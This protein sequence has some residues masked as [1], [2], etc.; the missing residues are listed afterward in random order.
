MSKG[1]KNK[2]ERRAIFPG[3][4]ID[5]ISTLKVRQQII[6]NPSRLKRQSVRHLLVSAII[7][8]M[9]M[10]ISCSSGGSSSSDMTM[11]E[12]LQASLDRAI[13]TYGGKGVSVAVIL[14]DGS[15]WIGTSGTS[16]GSVPVS[17]NMLFSIGSATKTFTAVVILQL[18]EDGVLTLEDQLSEWLP[19][20]DNIDS[21]I[22]I[23]QLLNHTSGI[24]NCTEHPEIWD[25]I[26]ADLYA[27]WTMEEIIEGYI[28]PPDF[29][30]GTDWHYSNTGYLLLRMIIK[31]ATGQSISSQYRERLFKPT[32]MTGM[33]TAI[34]E[35]P[36]GQVA[37]GW[38]DTDN[39]GDYDDFSSV[40]QTAFY[41]AIGGGVFASAKE[42][43]L[44]V[45]AVWH[46][47]ILLSSDYYDHMM[48]FHSPTPG[49]PLAAGYGLGVVLFNPDLFNGLTI[50]GHAGNP[51]GYAAGG[52]YLA[53]YGVSI[54]IL[55]NTE[56]G[57]TMPVINEILRIITKHVS[58]NSSN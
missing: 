49:E 53:D 37:N 56:E 22:T 54:A 58:P 21:T 5:T 16:T 35:S 3:Y 15:T 43:A 19:A 36:T 29:P 32:G 4:V 9:T 44:W 50:Y 40:P 6:Y 30:K 23:R 38:Y 14:P 8:L 27:Q 41:S 28:L 52:F 31:E 17:S 51:I 34:E 7:I 42:F 26:F 55:D 25:D 20:Y 48:D 47:R 13:G 24:Y 10:A 33:F 57:E 1:K 18:V 12:E 11:G 46:D 2:L 39:D 45:K